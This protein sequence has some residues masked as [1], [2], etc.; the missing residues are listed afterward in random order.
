MRIKY[1]EALLAETQ[2]QEKHLFSG[3]YKAYIGILNKRELLLLK[4]KEYAEKLGNTYS[5][6]EK[7]IILEIQRIDEK[8]RIEYYRQ[9]EEAKSELR[10]L[11]ELERNEMKYVNPYGNAFAAGLHFDEGGR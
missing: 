7:Q 1:L 5:E 2:E 4:I 10:K 11:N 8:N 6:E 9:I 3:N